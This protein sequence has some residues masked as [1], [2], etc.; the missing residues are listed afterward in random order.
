[1]RICSIKVQ[2]GIKIKA[3]GLDDV[4]R[5]ILKGAMRMALRRIQYKR[6]KENRNRLLYWIRLK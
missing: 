3:V 2:E 6:K 1:M 5:K 4:E